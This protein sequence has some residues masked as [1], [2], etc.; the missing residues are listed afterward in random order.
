MKIC[1]HKMTLVDV[2]DVTLVVEDEQQGKCSQDCFGFH[3]WYLKI[4]MLVN[5]IKSWLFRSVNWSYQWRMS[6]QTTYTYLSQNTRF[7]DTH[8]EEIY[9]VNFFSAG[10][11]D[12][13]RFFVYTLKIVKFASML[14]SPWI[15]AINYSILKWCQVKIPSA[16]R[17]C[18]VYWVGRGCT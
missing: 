10:L 8:L 3:Q 12:F 16:L 6:S 18:P 13:Q 5:Y 4:N 7:D 14:K 15:I 17:L 9:A 11:G 1:Q 2:R